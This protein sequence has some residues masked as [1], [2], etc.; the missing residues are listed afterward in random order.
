MLIAILNIFQITLVT[1]LVILVLLQPHG[2]SSLSE[3]SN[4]QHVFN[5]MIPIKSSIN[6]LRKIT[7]V[8]AG[9]FIINTLILSGISSKNLYY[10][11]NVDIS[12]SAI[13]KKNDFQ[14]I[15]FDDHA[16]G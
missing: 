9:L 6:P 4:S 2:S 3:F 14:S 7:S 8:V 11:N 1:I 13:T 12:E 16:E 5:A 10:N 15:P